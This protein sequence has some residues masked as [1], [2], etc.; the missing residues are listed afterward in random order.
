[1]NASRKSAVERVASIRERM[2]GVSEDEVR[3][4]IEASETTTESSVVTLSSA[5]FNTEE[6]T[7][8]L[9]ERHESVLT[10]VA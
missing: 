6:S 3:T 10:R 5:S 9:V 2:R 1:M 4:A 8:G 7:R